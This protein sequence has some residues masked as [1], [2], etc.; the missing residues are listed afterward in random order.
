VKHSY[1]TIVRVE[2]G[3]EE[4]IFAPKS[5]DAPRIP[6]RYRHDPKEFD[7]F[8]SGKTYKIDPEKIEAEAEEEIAGVQIEQ[9]KEEAAAMKAAEKK[10]R[11]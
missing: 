9:A 5:Q 1:E 11:K 3:V 10:T 2:S 6:A 8:K 4:T 7:K